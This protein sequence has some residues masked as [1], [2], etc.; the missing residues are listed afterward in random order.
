MSILFSGDFNANKNHELDSITKE[1]LIERH[2]QEKFDGIKYHI[3]LGDGG[4]M[5]PGN[6]KADQ[7]NYEALACRPFPV[8]CVMGNKDPILGMN[9][10]PEADSGI[11]ET[12]YQIQDKPFVAYL[13]RGK[14]CTIDGFKTLVLGGAFSAYRNKKTLNK[15][16]WERE[17][18]SEEEERDLFKL[19]KTENSFDCVLSHTGPHHIN[20]KIYYI[21]RKLRSSIKYKDKVAFLNDRIHQKIQFRE[22]L[23]GHWHT[24]YICPDK[25]TGSEHQY[26]YKVTKI[27]DRQDGKVMVYDIEEGC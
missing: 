18:W 16:W 24:D 3:I 2:G 11:G 19:L 10:V 22:W 26:L 23:C 4:F 5:Q 8:L 20:Q 1:A 27:M 25:E 6:A 15:T 21:N 12:V 14:V 17:Y 13:K 9:G 7:K